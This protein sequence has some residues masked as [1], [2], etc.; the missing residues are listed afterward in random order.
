HKR[1][2]SH[3]CV[4]VEKPLELAY[5]CLPEM[6]DKSFDLLRDKI[7]FS[8]ER[9][10][11][12]EEGKRLKQ[13]SPNSLKIRNIAIKPQIPVLLEYYTV[14]VDENGDVAF[15]N[16]VYQLDEQLYKMIW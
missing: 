2:I 14:F 9:Q 4:R 7:L 5:F 6:S 12:S 3:G 16:D 1:S 15:C 10:P 11:I 8:I 13:N